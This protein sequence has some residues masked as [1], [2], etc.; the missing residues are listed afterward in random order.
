MEF[1]SDGGEAIYWWYEFW[2]VRRHST[3]FHQTILASWFG[4]VVVNIFDVFCSSIISS[5]A[6]VMLA[7]YTQTSLLRWRKLE[8][9]Y[10]ISNSNRSAGRTPRE[11]SRIKIWWYMTIILNFGFGL[12]IRN[13]IGNI[14]FPFC[15]RRFQRISLVDMN[16]EK[17]NAI[18]CNVAIASRIWW[19]TLLSNVWLP[20]TVETKIQFFNII[21][22]IFYG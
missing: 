11:W 12:N 22:T 6:D 8:L 3:Q 21:T 4:M 19:W 16:F 13:T 7:G 1:L 15:R 2:R 10:H 14:R 17:K 20:Q 5:T 18:K 9:Y